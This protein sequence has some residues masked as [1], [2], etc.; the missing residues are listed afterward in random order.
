MA[1]IVIST[2]EQAQEF[3]KHLERCKIEAS[4]N[5]Y[6]KERAKPIKWMECTCCGRFYYGR[7]WWN[8]DHGYGLGDCCVRYCGVDPAAGPNPCYGVPGIHFLIDRKEHET[9]EE[10]TSQIGRIRVEALEQTRPLLNDRNAFIL[11]TSQ[12]IYGK[13]QDVLSGAP[14]HVI[15]SDWYTDGLYDE[16]LQQYHRGLITL[17]IAHATRLFD[18]HSA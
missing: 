18:E 16:G 9:P 8:Q 12:A 2:T 6:A 5:N 10:I 4:A 13:F 11:A 15:F 1:I 17:S 3:L 14:D 7:Q